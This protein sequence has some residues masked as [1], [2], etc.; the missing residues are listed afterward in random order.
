MKTAHTRELELR[1]ANAARDTP[2]YVSLLWYWMTHL[3]HGPKPVATAPLPQVGPGQVGVTFGGHATIRLGYNQLRIACDPML[4]HWVGP[5]KRAV[6]PGITAHDLRDV[7]VILIT[8]THRDHLHLPTL[9]RLPRTATLIVPPGVARSVSRLGFARSVEL[10]IGQS[11]QHRGVDIT[12]TPVHYLGSRSRPPLSYVVRGNGPSVFYCGDSGY[13][14]GFAEI[15]RRHRP[16]IAILPIGGYA[17]LSLRAEH[18]TPLDALYALEDLQ[19]RTMV[20]IHYGAFPLSYEHL[21]DP[22]NWLRK[23]V[24]ERNLQ[25]FVA[26]LHPGESRVFVLPGRNTARRSPSQRILS[27][28]K[29]ALPPRQLGSWSVGQSL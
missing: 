20:P 8:R 16:D 28:A 13:F 27:G 4:G 15:G 6:D 3:L 11:V 17:P 19:A 9:K 2:R 14:S 5:A 1:L 21:N 24:K 22:A 12:A 23:L 29:T 10:N 18:M 26:L 25:E 7:D